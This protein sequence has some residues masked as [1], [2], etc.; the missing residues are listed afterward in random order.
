MKSLYLTGLAL[1][2][3]TVGCKDKQNTETA[4]NE[5]GFVSLC[6]K[7]HEEAI[8]CMKAVNDS[9]SRSATAF[10]QDIINCRQ[11]DHT[12]LTTEEKNA[13][14]TRE[15]RV[16]FNK[17]I[18]E[19][20]PVYIEATVECSEKQKTLPEQKVC[21]IDAFKNIVQKSLCAEVETAP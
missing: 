8:A 13:T 5:S 17:R 4:S 2:F 19:M 20:V 11:I 7:L 18:G 1:A 16:A 10:S 3:F 12:K 6:N 9:A 15:Q 21:I 14:M